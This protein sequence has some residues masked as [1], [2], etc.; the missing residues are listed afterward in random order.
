L[1]I[2]WVGLLVSGQVTVLVSQWEPAQVTV[3]ETWWG[4]F[5]VIRS[6]GWW[7]TVLERVSV[8][9]LVIP[10]ETRLV[11]KL[12]YALE[13]LKVPVKGPLPVTV[14]GRLLGSVLETTSGHQSGTHSV[15][16]LV[17]ESVFVLETQLGLMLAF[18]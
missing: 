9:Q 8:L 5:P 17:T 12:G 6:V 3:L 16:V 14:L 2:V 4:T 15:T 13:K 1:E 18:D 11:V 7:G 10:Q